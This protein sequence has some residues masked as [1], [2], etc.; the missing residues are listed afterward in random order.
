MG[1]FTTGVSSKTIITLKNIDVDA[2]S[3][4]LKAVNVRGQV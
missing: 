3:V 1:T 2:R 4:S